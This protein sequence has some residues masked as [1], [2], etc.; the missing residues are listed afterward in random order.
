MAERYERHR[1]LKAREDQ[2]GRGG[3]RD[4]GRRDGGFRGR[5]NQDG[6]GF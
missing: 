1:E 4:S 5:R 6:W 2:E 3:R